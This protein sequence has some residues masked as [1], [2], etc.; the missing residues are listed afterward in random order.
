MARGRGLT[1]YVRMTDNF[2]GLD[3]AR[4]CM[5]TLGLFSVGN[6]VAIRQTLFEVNLALELAT[7][8]GQLRGRW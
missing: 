3:S 8:D 4:K 2:F 6:I 1:K 7:L 5:S